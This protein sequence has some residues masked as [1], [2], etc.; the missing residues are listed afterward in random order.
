MDFLLILLLVIVGLLILYEGFSVFWNIHARVAH[1]L[2]EPLILCYTVSAGRDRGTVCCSK[3]RLIE[4]GSASF[5]HT[6]LTLMSYAK[7]F[8]FR[9][10][11]PHLTV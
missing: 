4:H 8:I 5:E 2:H 7:L 9:K 6:C 11:P 1:T 10:P 3:A